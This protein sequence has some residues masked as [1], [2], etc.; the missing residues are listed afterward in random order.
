MIRLLILGSSFAVAD[1]RHRPTQFA[2]VGEENALLVDCGTCPRSR[3]EEMGVGRD[4]ITDLV[5]T[6]FHPDHVS[7]LAVFLSELWLSGRVRPMRIH[8]NSACISR[9]EVMLGLFAWRGWPN[10]FPVELLA[11]QEG[12]KVDVLHNS[13]YNVIATPVRHMVPTVAVRVDLAAGG[14]VVFS[15]DTE[16]VEALVRLAHYA[17]L[18]L[19]EAAGE[20]AGHS[21]AAQAGEIAGRAGVQRLILIHY[22][23]QADGRALV[24]L[25]RAA[26]PGEIDL[27]EDGM[28]ILLS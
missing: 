21:S 13:E 22:D 8:A 7:G 14:S 11:I 4:S 16:P 5:I 3:L 2:I 17:N 24:G 19:H 12:E 27:A 20:A 6:H 15:A 26:F 1:E 18:L 28:E 25:A 23:P 10:M 9:I